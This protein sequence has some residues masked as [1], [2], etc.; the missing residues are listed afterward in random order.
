MKKLLITFLMVG[1]LH[2]AMAYDYP[3]LVFQ[4]AEVFAK[5]YKE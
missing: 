2:V 1:T 3:Y 4:Q 5:G